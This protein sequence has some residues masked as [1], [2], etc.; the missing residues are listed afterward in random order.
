MTASPLWL[1]GF[2][3]F[4]ALAC[5]AGAILPVVWVAIFLGAV[6]PAPT[7]ALP[8][9]QWHAHEMFYGFGWAMLGGFLLTASK[10]WLGIRGYHGAALMFLAAA[11][12]VE[13]IGMVGGGAWPAALFYLSNLTFLAVVVAMLLATL[14]RHRAADS[15]R[16][17]AYFIFALPLF[18]PAKWLMLSPDGFAAGQAMTLALFRL[19]FLLMLERTLTQ[20]MKGVF[21]ISVPRYPLLDHA[22]KVL[23]CIA[24]FAA[25]LPSS[26]AATVDGVLAAVLLL[27]W[28]W[29]SPWRALRRLDIGIMY[30]GYAAIIAQLL[31]DLLERSGAWRGVGNLTLHT[32][33]VGAMGTIVPA[34]IVRLSK[35]HTGRKVTFDALDKGVLWLMLGGAFV[36]LALPQVAPSFYTSWLMLAA[37]CWLAAFGLLGWRYIPWLL[38]ARA[39]GREH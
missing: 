34:M 2:R 33:G 37:L 31:F 10:N 23:A 32:F 27:R 12:L 17:N 35:G 13:R 29:W 6:P 4:F 19:C 36:R 1:V 14:L 5:V 9:L 21:Q 15:Y 3:P 7:F 28:L 16:D 26:L 38:Q 22:I 18:L 39:D 30:L 11:W 8:A 20:F 25:W 24:I